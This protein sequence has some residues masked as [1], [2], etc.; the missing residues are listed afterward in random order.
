MRIIGIG[1][2]D[3]GDDAAGLLVARRLRELGVEA[4]EHS[5]DGLA[6]IE[7]WR[8]YDDVVLIDA[9]VTGAPAGAITRWDGAGAPVIADPVRASTHAFGVAEALKLARALGRMPAR[10]TI[11]GIEAAQ[12]EI[13]GAL[14]PEVAA[15]V[16]RLAQELSRPPMN[17]EERR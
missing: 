3:R 1:T 4:L 7:A 5:R 2:A 17:A 16:E 8:G 14:T 15:A 11:Y 6:L 12:F 13:G 9:V 10:L